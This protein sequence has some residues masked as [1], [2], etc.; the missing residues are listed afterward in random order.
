MIHCI[1][2]SHVLVFSGN[3]AVPDSPTYKD[4]LPF[5][6]TSW[7]GSYTA[8]NIINK[9]DIIEK[10]IQSRVEP[11][12]YVMFC[13]GEID[14]RAHLIRQS[15]IQIR[16]LHDIVHECVSRY[17]K[18]F[19]IPKKYG[20][21]VL[22]WNVP[23]SSLID[24]DEGEYSTYGDC[25]QRNEVTALF[26][27]TLRK[28]C[29]S[30]NIKFISI[31]DKLIDEDGLTKGQFFV[32]EIHLS[33][34]IIPFV[35]DELEKQGILNGSGKQ[36]APHSGF[37]KGLNL[38]HLDPAEHYRLAQQ[39]VQEGKIYEA[40]DE[41]Q[42][43]INGGIGSVDAHYLYAQLLASI[44]KYDE[45]I[46]VLNKVV[47]IMPW[48]THAF[49]DLAV[50]YFQK[51]DYD[52]AIEYYKTALSADNSNYTSLR[53]LLNL[54]KGL[55]KM[56][57]A[58]GIA[59]TL[60]ANDPRD[61][62]LLAIMREYKLPIGDVKNN[63]YSSTLYTQTPVERLSLLEEEEGPV[64]GAMENTGLRS[65][66]TLRKIKLPN[67]S[68]KSFFLK[69]LARDFNCNVFVESGTFAGDTSLTASKIFTAVHTIELSYELYQKAV[70]RLGNIE[71][72]YVYQGDSQRVL[73]QILG[74]IKGKIIF[75]LDGHYSAGVTAKSKKDTS[76]VEELK[77]IKNSGIRDSL[78]LVDDVRYFLHPNMPKDLST[79]DY[80]S[81]G[82]ICDLIHEIDEHYCFTVIGDVL[83]AY[84]ETDVF[85]VSPV[86][87]ACTVS[88]LFDGENYDADLVIDAEM[89][90]RFAKDE[91]LKTIQSL[92]K[93]FLSESP[94][95][96][97]YRLWHALTL[98]GQGL[99]DEA[100]KELLGAIGSGFTHWRL[101][102][103][104]AEA[105]F[106][107]G[108]KELAEKAL[109]KVSEFAPNSKAMHHLKSIISNNME[110]KPR[111]G[112]TTQENDGAYQQFLQNLER[113]RSLSSSSERQF[114]IELYPCLEDNTKTTKYDAQYVLHT[115]WAARVLAKIKPQK[116]I[117]IA[118]S[119]YFATIV[120]AFVPVSFYDYR[121]AD[122]NLSNLES[123][124]VDLTSLKFKNNSIQSLSCMHV[125][126]HIGLGRYGD[127]IDPDGDLKAISEIR[128]VMK[129]NGNL[130]FVVPVGK[131]KVLYNAHR[132]YSY[133]QILNYFDGFILK[134]FSLILDVDRE[135]L[136]KI[137]QGTKELA[138]RQN[139]GCGCFWFKKK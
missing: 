137:V 114:H 77:A 118:S 122:L 48:H 38:I 112:N 19:E 2:D 89:D 44:G 90:I 61:E 36:S 85:M 120:S 125:I 136:S 45:A 79:K 93:A 23:P 87:S 66:F 14:C 34:E 3:H 40:I 100:A 107:A 21:Q 69:E 52:K 24:I 108:E 102:V 113:F 116:H 51:K 12:D 10:V 46:P 22:I 5:F 70:L 138:D 101:Y 67:N 32:D 84:R 30:E 33:Q 28:Y 130:L 82:E 64:R 124:F 42:L 55:D 54:L 25:R 7:L 109:A 76:I 16:P 65:V 78:I 105:Y 123:G 128:R 119:I 15:E 73:P 80:P 1:G 71:N 121:P 43:A 8:Y 131:P 60:V 41:I 18:I 29:E 57:E 99:Y 96:A 31:F 135:G 6:R 58:I 68:L 56:D 53:N 126:E 59:R 127:Q 104:L 83:M 11:D 74:S 111:A 91:E 88:R 72:I 133:E 47:A 4:L 132:V 13:F 134:D 81:L 106:N 115:A 117:D 94:S 50:I 98:M 37:D 95:S 26:N 92:Y 17:A 39:L 49:N 86:V 27:E 75:W 20:L 63:N 62:Q 139:Y 97:Y 103:Y 129:Q 110:E 35:L 9:K